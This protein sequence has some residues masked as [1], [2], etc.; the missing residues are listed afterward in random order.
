MTA[1]DQNLGTVSS[2]I[3]LC[4]AENDAQYNKEG[5]NLRNF[6]VREPNDQT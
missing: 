3:T 4:H 1:L 5:Y 2:D 6:L